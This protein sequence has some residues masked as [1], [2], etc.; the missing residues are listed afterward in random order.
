MKNMIELYTDIVLM[1]AEKGDVL[2][3]NG[4]Q[5]WVTPLCNVIVQSQDLLEKMNIATGNI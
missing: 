5:C 4:T 3:I 2:Y 1:F